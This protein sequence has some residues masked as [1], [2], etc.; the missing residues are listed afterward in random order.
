MCKNVIFDSKL[1]AIKN[2]EI[3]N[4][5]L[6]M[7]LENLFIKLDQKP[8]THTRKKLRGAKDL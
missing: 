1:S 3:L 6:N 7:K 4:N 8:Y 5:S 2:D